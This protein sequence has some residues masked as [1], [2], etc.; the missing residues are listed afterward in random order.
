MREMCKWKSSKRDR[1]RGCQGQKGCRKWTKRKLKKRQSFCKEKFAHQMHKKNT[2]NIAIL[3]IMKHWIW[4]LGCMK[5]Q[6]K[7]WKS[8]CRKKQKT[9][10]DKR[11][12][13]DAKDCL[14]IWQ[15]QKCFVIGILIAA[16][17]V[18]RD[19]IGVSN[20]EELKKCPFCGGEAMLKINYG[21]DGKVISAF[22]YC[23]ECGVATRNCALEATARGMWN[24]RVKE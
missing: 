10:M 11:R 22:V 17:I 18:D 7:H 14:E 21:F 23:K 2:M 1:Q 24:R 15:I 5:Q 9:G 19:Q 12:V 4:Q 20:M 6:S 8:S 13:L 3:Y 16:I